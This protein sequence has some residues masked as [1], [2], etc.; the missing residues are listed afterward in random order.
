MDEKRKKQQKLLKE[1]TD[2]CTE[3]NWVMG[4]PKDKMT[5]G[6]I[7][8]HRQ[9]VELTCNAVYGKEGYEIINEKAEEA[10]VDE[11]LATSDNV[12]DFKVVELTEEEF[13]QFIETGDLPENVQLIN[14]PNK[15]ITY[16]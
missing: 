15:G 6:V 8:G 4:I 14:D 16:H 5:D 2:I 12:D 10:K 3:L 9:Y 7:C 11:V 1:L 13:K